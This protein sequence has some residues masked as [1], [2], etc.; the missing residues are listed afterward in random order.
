MIRAHR[1]GAHEVLPA[2]FGLGWLI[3]TAERAYPGTSGRAGQG[4]PGV[5]R[6]RLRRHPGERVP[7]RARG[8]GRKP[9][10]GSW[11]GPPCAARALTDGRCR[12]TEPS[13]SWRR[14]RCPRSDCR[15]RSGGAGAGDAL[16]LY[17]SGVLFHA[18]R[19]QG[20]RDILEFTDDRLALRCRLADA[21][22]ARGA[23]AGARHSPVLTDILLQGA[24]A[25]G[26]RT[27]ESSLPLGVTRA[28]YYAPLPGGED[29]FVVIDQLRG[30]RGR[31]VG[32]RD[33]DRHLGPAAGAVQRH[34]TRPDAG[35]G[36]Q[37][38]RGGRSLAQ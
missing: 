11:S 26:G 10:A 31:R 13:W 19:L 7:G 35:H 14:H 33:R 34:R 5:P 9:A 4:L 27:R 8:R 21:A 38:R 37:I 1:I 32:R 16:F 22:V 25:L 36:R 28:D 29:F 20:I 2:C 12:T 24:L 3:N 30:D 6:H 17:T 23:F 18:P 15:C